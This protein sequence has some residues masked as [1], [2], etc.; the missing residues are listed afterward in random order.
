MT[1]HLFFLL[2]T[3]YLPLIASLSTRHLSL[4]SAF[5]FLSFLFSSLVTAFFP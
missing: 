5:C 1:L 3:D 2:T 4:L